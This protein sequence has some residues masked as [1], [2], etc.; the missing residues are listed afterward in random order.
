MKKVSG[1]QSATVCPLPVRDAAS[2]PE[3]EE[4]RLASIE[5]TDMVKLRRNRRTR[6]EN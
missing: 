1:E 5:V 4:Q 2:Y 3:T 6:K